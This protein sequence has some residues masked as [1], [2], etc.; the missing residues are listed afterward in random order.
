VQRTP[1]LAWKELVELYG[2]EEF[3]RRR[4]EELKAFHPQDEDELLALA[5]RYLEGQQPRDMFGR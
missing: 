5:D 4:I 3:L 1:Q 2:A